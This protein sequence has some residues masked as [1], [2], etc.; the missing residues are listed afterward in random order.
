MNVSSY[1]LTGFFGVSPGREGIYRVKRAD[2]VQAF[3]RALN[4]RTPVIV[5]F[6]TV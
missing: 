2:A 1:L 6:S 5:S 3:A 4:D